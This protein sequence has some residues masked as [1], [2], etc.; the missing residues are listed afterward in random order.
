MKSCRI[1][2]AIKPFTDI[3]VPASFKREMKIPEDFKKQ[4]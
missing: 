4:H 1:N 3:S 2:I